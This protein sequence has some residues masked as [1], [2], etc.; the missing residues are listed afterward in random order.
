MKARAGTSFL[1]PAHLRPLRALLLVLAAALALGG[2]TGSARADITTT[3]ILQKTITAMPSC[4]KYQVRGMCFFLHCTL[5]ACSIKSSIRVSHY[6]PD[7]IVSTYNDPLTH[8]WTDIGK[9]VAK[10]TSGA[11]SLM[12]GMGVDSSADTT[13][14]GPH[15]SATFKSADAIGNPA[16]MIFQMLS[17]GGTVAMP[18]TLPI[19]SVMELM[20]FPTTLPAIQQQWMSVPKDVINNGAASGAALA[21]APGALM[22]KVK[23]MVGDFQ[24]VL[25]NIQLPDLSSFGSGSQSGGGAQ[26]SSPSESG[27]APGGQG[28]QSGGSLDMGGMQQVA[29]IAAAVSGGSGS[30]LF[31]PGSASIFTL[32]FQSELDAPFWRG[33]LPLELLY[34]GSWIPTLEEVSESPTVSTWGGR[35]PR[36]GQVVQQHP[37]KASAV[38][39][40]RVA[41]IIKQKAQPHIYT[42]LTP[43]PGFKYFDTLK[44]TRWQMLS[45]SSTGCITF[46]END[47]LLPTAFGDFKTSDTEGYA[48]NMWNRYDCCQIRGA[49]LFSIP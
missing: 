40:E 28:G 29:D 25:S 18:S 49:F 21:N 27:G 39:A 37:V 41:S 20:Q 4:I 34:P 5:F 35:Y 33:L 10:A 15:E 46:G 24:S 8:P 38:Y 30:G 11:G 12:M 31:C 42:P 6:V 1:A 26:T 47:S 45:P 48:W 19:P 43:G 2:F 14:R 9:L 44:D 13:Q 23:G 7:A 36:M 3:Q 32:H 17:S 16:G 22:D